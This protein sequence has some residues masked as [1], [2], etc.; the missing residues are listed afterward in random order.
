MSMGTK[1]FITSDS[2]VLVSGGARGITAKCVIRLAQKTQCRFILVGR[3]GLSQAEPGYAAN[4][5]DENELKKRIMLDLQQ[6][7]EKPTPQ[8]IQKIYKDIQVQREIRETLQAIQSAGGAA[9][10]VKA[11][12]TD[13]QSLKAA[14]AE[15]TQRLG[16]IS[17]IIHGAGNLA[18]KLI[19]KKSESDFET[20]YNPKILG[21]EKLLDVVPVSQL[22]FLVL[23]SSIVGFF[24]NVGQS[25][26]AIANEILNK[27]AYGLK[28]KNPNVRVIAFDWGPWDAGMVTPELKKTFETRHVQVIPTDVGTE[29]FVRELTDGQQDSIQVI[30]GNLPALP[31]AEPD[32]GVHHYQIERKLSL[33]ANPFLYDHTIGQNPV[34]PATCAATWVAN[35]CEQLYPGYVFYSLDNYRVLKGIVFDDT[36]ADSYTLEMDERVKND[37]GDITFNALIWSKNSKGRRIFHYKVSLTLKRQ[38]LPIPHIDLHLENIPIHPIPGKQFYEDGTLFHGASFQGVKQVLSI[39]QGKLLMECVLPQLDPSL[40]GQFPVQTSN[41]YIYDAIV[42][43]LLIWAQ[44]YYQAPC[45]PA[46]MVKLE[47][48]KAIPFETSC[49]VSMEVKSHHETSVVADITVSDMAGNI[50]VIITG[51]EGTISRHLKQ[52]IQGSSK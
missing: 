44:T 37:D 48:F 18:D 12:I 28:R 38:A 33:E 39:S 19:E 49:L 43:S 45:L 32:P 13:G 29:V 10:Y 50:Y 24:G 6:S 30:V 26:Y 34:L 15:P 23:F 5:Q 9:E 1:P 36:L 52:V 8:K 20:V 31:A 40:T 35:A 51:L 17:G 21:L 7:G 27:T 2:V 42:Q 3:S 11:D 14:I 46:S 16:P 41:P 25:D 4:C 22:R 47:Q